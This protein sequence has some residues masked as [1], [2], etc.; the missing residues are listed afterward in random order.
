MLK[1]LNVLIMAIKIAEYVLGLD[2]PKIR[3]SFRLSF[4]VVKYY[5][6]PLQKLKVCTL[7]K[8]HVK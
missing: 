6:I 7:K 2:K 3:L 1:G 5:T 4:R 8:L